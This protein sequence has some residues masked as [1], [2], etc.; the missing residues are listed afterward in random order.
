MAVANC[1]L[2]AD[3][4]CEGG[5][6]C[7][8]CTPALPSPS[9]RCLARSGIT[10]VPGRPPDLSASLGG[11]CAWPW[12]NAVFLPTPEAR[13]RI[14]APLHLYFL[15]FGAWPGASS[16]S[17]PSSPPSMVGYCRPHQ[18]RARILF[19]RPGPRVARGTAAPVSIEE[20]RWPTR[21][22]SIIDSGMFF[23]YVLRSKRDE[24]SVSYE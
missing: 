6:T 24:A 22:T 20:L 8:L 4:R 19:R 10:I 11:T 15:H 12:P 18:E 1:C 9:L 16:P 21:V 3:T 17:C 7:P 13:E 14:P 5:D 23:F 2:L